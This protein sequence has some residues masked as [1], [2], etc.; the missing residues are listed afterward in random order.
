[1]FDNIISVSEPVSESVSVSVSVKSE[2]KSKSS[3][4]S[5]SLFVC[6]LNLLISK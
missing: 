6:P 1:M 4:S 3:S 5:N 2:S